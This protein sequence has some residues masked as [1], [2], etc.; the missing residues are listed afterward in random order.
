MA[1][2]IVPAHLTKRLPKSLVTDRH[3]PF[4][5][6]LIEFRRVQDC[7]LLCVLSVLSLQ[8]GGLADCVQLRPASGST[9][10]LRLYD[11]SSE[12]W[13]QIQFDDK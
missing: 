4:E 5:G 8:P 13:H 9:W 1:C 6:Q 10:K 11:S 12:A 2:C 7:W 3:R